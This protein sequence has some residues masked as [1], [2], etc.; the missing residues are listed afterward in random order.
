[1]KM[2]PTPEDQKYVLCDACN[3]PIQDYGIIRLGTVDPVKR[4]VSS[5]RKMISNYRWRLCPKHFKE[6]KNKIEEEIKNI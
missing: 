4:Y 2:K 6:V 5:N 3:K 1:M